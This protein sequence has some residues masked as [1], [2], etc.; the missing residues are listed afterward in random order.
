MKSKLA[1]RLPTRKEYDTLIYAPDRPEAISNNFDRRTINGLAKRY[2]VRL[3]NDGRTWA[4][5]DYG[6]LMI[7]HCVKVWNLQLELPL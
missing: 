4:I 7:R 6:K 1:V 3:D 2:L 5:T